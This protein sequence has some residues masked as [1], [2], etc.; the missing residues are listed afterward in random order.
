MPIHPSNAIEDNL[1]PE[2]HLGMID[3]KTVTVT[4]KEESEA[5]KKRRIAL[6]HLPPV[7]A[8]LNL[9]DFERCSKEILTDQAWAYYSSAGDDEISE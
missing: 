5:D 3:P 4:Q 7:G 1:E 9:D 6:E 8:M 2:Q